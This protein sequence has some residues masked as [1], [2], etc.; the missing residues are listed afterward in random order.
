MPLKDP[1]A[2]KRY[3]REHRLKNLAEYTK[4]DR[5]YRESHKEEI[6]ERH[7]KYTEDN[8]DKHRAWCQ[9]ANKIWR[10]KHG[11]KYYRKY[12]R[13]KGEAEKITARWKVREALKRGTLSRPDYC[14]RCGLKC[15]PHAHHDD[16]SKPLEVIWLC[17]PCHKQADFR[18]STL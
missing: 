2:R 3:N 5:E 1:E 18:R 13:K 6:Y 11:A 12:R 8:R 17:N 16:Y 7:R 14:S 15:K 10:K 4:R 9:K